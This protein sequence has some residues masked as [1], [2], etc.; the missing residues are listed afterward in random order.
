MFAIPLNALQYYKQYS[1]HY[2]SK[3]MH[4]WNPNVKAWK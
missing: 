3:L 2:K 1:K 4:S